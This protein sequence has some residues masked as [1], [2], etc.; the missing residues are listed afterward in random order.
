MVKATAEQLSLFKAMKVPP[1]QHKDLLEC[2]VQKNP[3]KITQVF[4]SN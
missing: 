3:T 4:P 1:P 2:R